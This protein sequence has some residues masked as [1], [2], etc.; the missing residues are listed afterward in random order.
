MGGWRRD[1]LDLWEAKRVAKDL[2]QHLTVA[3]A[4]GDLPS[5]TATNGPVS[6]YPSP[7]ADGTPYSKAMRRR[8]RRL[9]DHE[10]QPLQA[11]QLELVK[12]VP[13]MYIC[14]ADE[15]PPGSCALLAIRVRSGHTALKNLPVIGYRICW[16]SGIGSAG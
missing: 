1:T 3:D 15:M 5:L 11:E 14:G 16:L 7:A 10:V 9:R 4:I 6:T 12:N 2:L 8:A 13:V